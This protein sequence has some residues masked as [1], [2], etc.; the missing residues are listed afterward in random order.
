L[1]HSQQV[2]SFKDSSDAARLPG[3]PS[4]DAADPA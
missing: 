1:T 2:L 4:R 3:H